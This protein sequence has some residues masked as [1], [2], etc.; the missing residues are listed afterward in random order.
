[1]LSFDAKSQCD[2]AAV[3]AFA[4]DNDFGLSSISVMLVCYYK[5]P[6]P[7]QFFLTEGHRDFGLF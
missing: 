6:T 4:S 7:L 5:V 1:M 3:I 2:T